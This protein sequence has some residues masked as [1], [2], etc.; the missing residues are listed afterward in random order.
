MS[1]KQLI[2]Q[3]PSGL[4]EEFIEEVYNK[5]EQDFTKSLLELWNIQERKQKEFTKSQHE[6]NEVRNTCDSF[7]TE[8][9][10]LISNVKNSIKEKEKDD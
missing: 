5:N 10:R 9:N 6:W 4:T 8:L 2:E 1:I 3:S 7:D